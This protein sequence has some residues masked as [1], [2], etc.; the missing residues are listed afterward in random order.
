[1]LPSVESIRG[2]EHAASFAAAWPCLR[3]LVLYF[4]FCRFKLLLKNFR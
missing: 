1:L 2:F 4:N 3:F